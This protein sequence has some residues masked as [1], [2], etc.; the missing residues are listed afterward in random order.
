MKSVFARSL[1]KSYDG[2]NAVDGIDLDVDEGQIFGFLGPNGA[3]K[4]TVIKL[5][6][7]LI[8][9]T[10]GKISVLKI[11]ALK[12]PLKI[13]KKIGVVLQQPSYEPTL[14]VEKS[15]EK[16]GMMWNLD[17]KTRN[18]RTEELLTA[19]N[20]VEIRKK[21]NEDLSIGQRRRVQVAR[22]FMH[23]MDLLFLDEPT[24]GLDPTARRQLLDFLRNKVKET[25]LTIFYTTHVL[26]EAEYLCDNIAI[27]NKGR[28]VT[29]DSPN[30]LKNRFGH[31]KTIKIHVSSN[32]ETL[33]NLLENIQD[34]KIEFN[35]GATITI[36]STNSELVLMNVLKILNQNNIS[37]DDLSAIPTNLE[38]IFL[39]VVSDSNASDNQI[40]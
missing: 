15:L 8:H 9:P 20:L 21:K 29:I 19:F 34:C 27:I 36:Q 18:D 38:E 14:S 37:I 1:F 24:V 6:T 7:T 12:E 16:Y 10:S 2:I 17:K 25:N 28:I 23:D 32:I 30:E 26:T 31:E 22:E 39:K 33:E 3:G 40:S 11:D 4:S 13:R 5:L 35:T